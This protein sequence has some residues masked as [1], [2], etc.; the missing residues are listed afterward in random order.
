MKTRIHHAGFTLVEILVVL[1]IVGLISSILLQ[2]LDQVYKLQSRFGLQLAQS[3]Q[4]AM[5]TDWFRQAVQGFQTDYPD[6]K[7]KFKADERKIEG[8]TTNPLS[9]DYGAPTAIT[10]QLEYEAA[11]DKTTL[12]YAAHDRKMD[13]FSWSGKNN[14]RFIFIDQA[15]A[16]H[17]SWPPVFGQWPQLPSVILLQMQQDFAPHIIAATPR[18]SRETKY[19]PLNLAG[20][21]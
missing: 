16:P 10:L 21:P 4:G 15:G 20:S 1:V 7:N 14:G 2:A 11:A 9:A 6:G 13:L 17:D 8:L 5:Y 12:K 18:G 3:Q 19:H